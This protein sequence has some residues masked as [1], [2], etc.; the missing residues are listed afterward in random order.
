MRSTP[1]ARRTA[2]AIALTVPAALISVA[3]P[4]QAADPAAPAYSL[5]STVSP[6]PLAAAECTDPTCIVVAAPRGGTLDDYA[7]INAA[8]TT[9]ASRTVPAVMSADGTVATPAVTA[10]V[11][12]RSG[13]YRITKGLKLPPNVNLQGAGIGVTTLLMDPTV[14]W[15]N[16]SYSYLVLPNGVDQAGSTNLVSDLTVNGN[17]RT[18]A[19]APT[20]S[21]L[22]GR[23]GDACDF[24]APTG[25]T[26]NTGGGIKVGD[27]WTVRQVRFTNFEYFKLWVNGTKDAHIIDNRFDNWGGAESDG[28]DNIGGGGL[29]ENTV[30]EYNQYDVTARGNFFDFTNAVNTTVR[31]NIVHTNRTVAAARKVTEYGNLY[32][33]GVMGGTVTGNVLEGS[34]IVLQSNA[35]YSHVAPNKDINQPRDILVASNHI[36]DSATAGVAIGYE[37]YLDSDNTGGTPDTLMLESAVGSVDHYVRLGGNNIVRDNVIERSRESGILVYGNAAVKNSPDTIVGNRVVDSGVAG[38]LTYNTGVGYFETAGIGVSAGTGDMIYGNE[39]VDDQ[40]RPTTWYGVQIGARKGTSV[41]TGTVLTGPNG[42]TNT[43]TGIVASPVRYG[44]LAPE[45]P[46]GLTATASGLTWSESYATTNPIAGYRVYRDGTLLADLPVGSAE[47][48]GNLYT[49]DEASMESVTAGL[50]GWTAGG[51]TTVTRVDT[52]GALGGA[53]L[54]VKATTAGQISAYGRKV[55]VTAGT[56]YTAVASFQAGTT[57]RRVRAGLAYVDAAGKITRLGSNNTATVDSTT[58]WLTSSYSAA[59]PAGSVTVQAF[60]M[61]EGAAVG[62]AHLIDRMGLVTGS[63]TE[64]WADPAGTAGRYDVVSYAVTGDN[65]PVARVTL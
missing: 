45:A 5:A 61:V 23:P 28:E 57:A 58:G 60:L 51:G 62:E 46:A 63:V 37:D 38:S 18:D 29:N 59:A 3:G 14:N 24:L 20:P 21:A 27:R 8:I 2:A 56:T 4:V 44:M 47:V 31:N 12:L 34:H 13:T 42:E 32:F 10:T 40:A 19:G 64:Q 15:R 41:P 26:G 1:T 39:I 33:E 54:Q 16:F 6:A 30:I 35:R 53:S 25:A 48:P 43:T 17:C 55:P 65:S 49:A 36:M 7:V 22:P 52:A 50:A 11:L 9:A